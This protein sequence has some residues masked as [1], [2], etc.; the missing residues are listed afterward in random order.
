MIDATA[1]FD[2]DGDRVV[3]FALPRYKRRFAELRDAATGVV[4]LRLEPGAEA[5]TTAAF[6]VWNPA[7][8][9]IPMETL[10]DVGAPA[11]AV[12]H[13]LLAYG[14]DLGRV[15]DAGTGRA[16]ADLR[17]A[18]DTIQEARFSTDGRLIATWSDGR[19]AALPP[20]SSIHCSRPA[21][22]P[23]RY[24]SWRASSAIAALMPSF[25]GTLAISRL[26]ASPI[27][28]RWPPASSL[29]GAYSS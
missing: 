15:L 19:A 7:G 6:S 26:S 16:I 11:R 4:L 3:L 24:G 9:L 14:R 18:R 29:G 25:C 27:P 2:R 20:S 5:P 1:V 10:D 8:A 22:E 23:G 13:R 28:G 21:R 12:G 17:G